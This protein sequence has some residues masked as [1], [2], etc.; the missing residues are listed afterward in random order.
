[1]KKKI[2]LAVALC[3]VIV[4][5]LAMTF[6]NQDSRIELGEYKGVSVEFADA[7]VTDEDV[8]NAVLSAVTSGLSEVEITNRPAASGDTVNIDFEGKID[9][10]AFDGGTAQAA[11]LTIGSG[12]FIDGFEDQIIG[13]NTGETKDLSVTFPDTYSSNADL[14][15][16]DAVFTVKVNTIKGKEIPSEITDEMI[17]SISTEYST[18]ADFRAYIRENLE[19]SAASQN[20]ENKQ[21]AVWNKVVENATVHSLSKE[22]TEY[23]TQLLTTYYESYA[24]TY[25]MTVD[26][27][28][29]SYMGMTKEQFDEQNK[30]YVSFML[31]T[32]EIA[33]A[34]AKEENITVTEEEYQAF[35]EE[36]GVT[37]DDLVL[38]ERNFRDDLVYVKVLEFVTANAVFV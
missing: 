37:G 29:Q 24:E 22:K 32:Y 23:Y 34:I 13:M 7:V 10:V 5:V 2:A 36:N 30:E 16:R 3:A 33:Q 14:A 17:Q 19:T 38:Y 8:D 27:F 20:K 1:M 31:E 35:V 12:T 28:I 6:G 26:E 18:V 9:G 21:S 25:E 15:G 11:D 4:A